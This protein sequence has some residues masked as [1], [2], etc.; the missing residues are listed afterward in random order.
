MSES[1]LSAMREQVY[2]FRKLYT[3]QAE[4]ISTLFDLDDPHPHP[5][6]REIFPVVIEQLLKDVALAFWGQWVDRPPY[7]GWNER[8]DNWQRTWL[9]NFE[10]TKPYDVPDC[11][12]T[13]PT[14]TTIHTFMERIYKLAGECMDNY[15]Y[16][17]SSDFDFFPES[18]EN[19]RLE[20][21]NS[22]R[23]LHDM[24]NNIFHAQMKVED[25]SQTTNIVTFSK[26]SKEMH[27]FLIF[28]YSVQARSKYRWNKEFDQRQW[29][30]RMKIVASSIGSAC[31]SYRRR[32]GLEENLAV[33]SWFIQ[34]KRKIQLLADAD[35]RD[36][37][38][39]FMD[40]LMYTFDIPIEKDSQMIYY[41]VKDPGDIRHIF[42]ENEEWMKILHECAHGTLHPSNVLNVTEVIKRYEGLQKKLAEC[43]SHWL[44]ESLKQSEHPRKP[45]PETH[46]S[47]MQMLAHLRTV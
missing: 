39:K 42:Q 21:M 6:H 1:E 18:Y 29:D 12:F 11:A 43:T 22:L 23:T 9:T 13:I 3:T 32:L 37:P 7:P 40:V 20:V 30:E 24:L 34:M 19:M 28:L 46:A 33:D 4:Y 38:A 26:R 27:T 41:R 5:M 15:S 35:T 17:P 47:L 31:R 10:S 44:P 45:E 25:F 16:K 2:S 14:Q 36:Q 8:P